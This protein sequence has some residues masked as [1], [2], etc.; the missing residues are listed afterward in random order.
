MK[1]W[2]I[3]R[4]NEK[5][6]CVA[7]IR[8]HAGPIFTAVEGQGYLFTGGME[9][10]VRCW[11]LPRRI[12]PGQAYKKLLAGSWNNSEDQKLQPIWQLLYYG[13]RV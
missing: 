9:G 3:E 7:T 6:D 4:P 10:I 1:I 11:D 5:V 12:V 2:N 13:D 8:Q